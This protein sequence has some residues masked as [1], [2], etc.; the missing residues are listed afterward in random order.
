MPALTY[1]GSHDEVEIP[2]AGVVVKRG[3]SFDCYDATAAALLEQTDN[4]KAAT[5]A[6][7]A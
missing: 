3:E 2:A 7:G 4:Y 1:I 5:K 6:K